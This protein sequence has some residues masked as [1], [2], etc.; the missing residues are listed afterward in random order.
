MIKKF[1][2]YFENYTVNNGKYYD[3]F[4]TIFIPLGDLRSFLK[5]IEIQKII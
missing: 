4:M 3:L 5:D 2:Q 1:N